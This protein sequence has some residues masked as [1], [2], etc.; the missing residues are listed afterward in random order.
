MTQ[1][2]LSGPISTAVTE[3]VTPRRQTNGPL[4]VPIDC[5]PALWA[6]F[7]DT[8]RWEE[9][10][11][12]DDER[13]LLE[14][15]MNS[16]AFGVVIQDGSGE[17]HGSLPGS[18]VA[19]TAARRFFQECA[20]RAKV[21]K[22]RALM[23]AVLCLS[24][25][26]LSNK[27]R[28]EDDRSRIKRYRDISTEHRAQALHLLRVAAAAK[29]HGEAADILPAIMILLILATVSRWKASLRV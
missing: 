6:F 3:P 16:T 28:T 22:G 29:S 17:F 25:Q 1:S 18:R 4:A 8:S 27:A 14:Y 11:P 9:Q 12:N 5:D 21:E 7:V 24:A 20:S 15:Y 2:L 19:L 23:H 10:E 26:H 13:S